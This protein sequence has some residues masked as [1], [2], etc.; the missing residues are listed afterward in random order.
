MGRRSR[1][2]DQ[3]PG[4]SQIGQVRDQ[5]DAFDQPDTGFVA[6]LEAKGEQ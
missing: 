5:L 4:I 6:P 3:R 2:D 1:V